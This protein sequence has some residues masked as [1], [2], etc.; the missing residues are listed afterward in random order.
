MHAFL[1]QPQ[2][3]PPRSDAHTRHAA[4]VCC[5]QSASCRSTRRRSQ[6]TAARQRLHTC[7]WRCSS[8][9]TRCC[10][11][12]LSS[13]ASPAAHAASL[14]RDWSAAC[15]QRWQQQPTAAQQHQQ[16][17][18]SWR[19]AVRVPMQANAPGALMRWR[20][21][22]VAACLC[23][24]TAT[25]ACR[26]ASLTAQLLRKATRTA[27]C[28]RVQCS[29]SLRRSWHSTWPSAACA[30]MSR[31]SQQRPAW[32]PAVLQQRPQRTQQRRR[33]QQQAARRLPKAQL[34]QQRCQ[35]RARRAAPASARRCQATAAALSLR[36]TCS[37]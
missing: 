31:P 17:T 23:A 4:V 5:R 18:G 8:A 36:Q 27:A 16:R 15:H 3:L 7:R 10:C 35:Q 12:V 25:A 1:Q 22:A 29:C 34:Q 26:A 28:W 13:R 24:A 19:R 9:A 37:T 11:R 14:R 33:R 32:P 6:P 20:Q 30:S 21:A 2:Q